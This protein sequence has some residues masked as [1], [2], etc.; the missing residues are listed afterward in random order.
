[1][2]PAHHWLDS[3]CS[4]AV[5]RGRAEALLDLVDAEIPVA[6]YGAPLTGTALSIGAYQHAQIALHPGA[7]V[8]V[9]RRSSGGNTVYAGEGVF[10][11]AVALD[12]AS[13]LMDCPP[14]RILNRNVRGVLQG[15]RLCGVAAH[16]F[17][18]DYVSVI[19]RPGAY[20][21][22]DQRED[23]RVLFEVFVSNSASFHPDAQHIAYPARQN[24]PYRGHLPVTLLEA[25]K[26]NVPNDE[27]FE[28]LLRGH[29]SVYQVD[30]KP[31]SA[32]DVAGCVARGVA[33]M[34]EL[35]PAA[36]EGLV[37]SSAYEEA[38]GFVYAG[39]AVNADHTLRQVRV[40]G[41]YFQNR[42]GQQAL[43]QGLVG[44]A[45]DGTSIGQAINDVYADTR[46]V[47]EGIRQMD[48]LRAV[49]LS[50]VERGE[51]LRPR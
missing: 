18:R 9:V 22:W 32:E 49:V 21:A 17:G 16:Y 44:S 31:L 29:A 51:P 42:L 38:I 25:A 37:W 26:R 11:F 19:S 47:I 43:E 46:H 36:A 41:D 2:T 20:I 5:S 34:A 50:A 12:D 48:S 27:L 30:S 4:A 10:H 33:R 3:P 14:G 39:V 13:A 7:K 8:P 40:G 6:F 15:L 1:M 35:E 24:D 45:I 28:R 23:G